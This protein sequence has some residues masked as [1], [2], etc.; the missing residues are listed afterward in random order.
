M[1]ARQNAIGNTAGQ[2]VLRAGSP[3]RAARVEEG[4]NGN[5]PATA[6]V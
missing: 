3:A 5:H 2:G 1:P 4:R 6:R